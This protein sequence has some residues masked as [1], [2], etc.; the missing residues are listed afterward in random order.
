M[1]GRPAPALLDAGPP[2]R[3]IKMITDNSSPFNVG[4][5]PPLPSFDNS[6]SANASPGQVDE[7]VASRTIQVVVAPDVVVANC[8]PDL[9]GEVLR[10]VPEE[11]QTLL[12]A[13]RRGAP[14]DSTFDSAIRFRE[15]GISIL[16]IALNGTKAPYSAL[17][18][19]EQREDAKF[20][21]TWKPLQTRLATDN[22]LKKW[23]STIRT[24]FQG[25]RDL[26]KPAGIGVLGGPISGNLLILDF[27]EAAAY[28]EWEAL[29]RHYAEGGGFSWASM[30]LVET[31]GGGRHLYLKLTS[32][33]PGNEKLAMRPTTVEELAINPREKV[34][35]LIETRGTGGYVVAPG[36]PAAC[37]KTGR[38]YS[39]LNRGWIESSN[40]Q[41]I[42]PDL[43]KFMLETARSLDRMPVPPDVHP[44]HEP[45]PPA[46]P[47]YHR[48]PSSNGDADGN[49]PGDDYNRQARWREILTDW[50]FL[51]ARSGE[52][53]Y[54]R[55]PGKDNGISASLG[56]L[57][58]NDGAPMLY[59]FSTNASPLEVGY[60]TPFAAYTALNHSGDFSAAARALAADGYGA[61]RNGNRRKQTRGPGSA[62]PAIAEP[63]HRPPELVIRCLSDLKARPVHYLVPGRIARGKVTLIAGRGGSG[64]SILMRNLTAAITTGTCA[65][66]LQY[67]APPPGKVLLIAAEDGVEDTVL[68]HLLCEG[69]DLSRVE[70]LDGI[71]AADST[72][73]FTL[74]PAHIEMLRVRVKQA[75]D[76]KAIVIDPITSY[77][78]RAD[79]DDHKAAEL[80]LVLDP[81]NALAE[82]T[83][84]AII[85]LAH[86]NKGTGEAVDRI[87]GSAAYR[88]AV[89]AAYLV[90]P[91]PEDDACRLLMPIKEN[92]PGFNRSAIPF[93]LVE[94]TES[95][96]AAVMQSEQLMTLLE[97]ERA[98]IREQLHRV[99]FDAPCAS[100]P[101]HVMKPATAADG[102]KVQRCAEWLR[103]FLKDFAYPS[104]EIIEAAKMKD[105]TVD[106]VKKGKTLLKAEGLQNSNRGR[107]HAAWWSGFGPPS[108]WR[109]RPEPHQLENTHHTPDSPHSGS[110]PM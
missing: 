60:Y 59:V 45:V 82:E 6:A 49:R 56:H 74:R 43:L 110:M 2:L 7:E 3:N 9:A 47:V 80:R 57:K 39:W 12:N 75:P 51:S 50:R 94:L 36:S 104:S 100:D 53:Q 81:L 18:P 91:D 28:F 73:T 4:P 95:E 62:G 67:E 20:H 71:K 90:A 83:G 99:V 33:P 42:S 64:K 52:V 92:L 93:R 65:F 106:N 37:H 86:L 79:V 19:E 29:V 87:A 109:L 88:D 58:M 68:P 11:L 8:Q 107:S 103:V 101:N 35:T 21:R 38:K 1:I 23:F 76:I 10:P 69:A 70:V 5:L 96:V 24:D 85:I 31:P 54:V 77:V 34:K 108:A 97:W 13:P 84:I 48:E 41:F 22:E 98:I 72:S 78:G 105:F 27:E 63:Q 17:L 61:P 14:T 102:N 26:D 25:G 16:P 44:N 55:R 15:L 66:G 32:T 30:P 46:V 40:V 89:R